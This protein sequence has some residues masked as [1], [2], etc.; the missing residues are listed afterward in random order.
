MSNQNEKQTKIKITESSFRT[1]AD[2]VLQYMHDFGSIT[3]LDAMKDLGV[4]RLAARINDLR[5]RGIQITSE[6]VTG[7][8]RY[9]RTIHYARY[10][11]AV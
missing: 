6:M 1:Q 7:K 2:D 9:G 3:P 8:N 11:K 10:K 5:N 4:M